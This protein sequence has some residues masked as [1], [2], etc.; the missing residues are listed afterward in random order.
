VAAGIGLTVLPRLGARNL[1]DGVVAV[2]VTGPTPQR[3]I[4]ALVEASVAD[5][6]PVRAALDALADCAARSLK[7]A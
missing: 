4:Y 3:A 7:E 6:A 2:P 5:T 1:P